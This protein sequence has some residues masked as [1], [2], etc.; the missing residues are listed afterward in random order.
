[1]KIESVR[2][3][4]F[5]GFKDDTITFD[6]YTCFVGANGAGKSTVLA[7]LNVFF[8]QYRDSKTDLSRLSV[9]DFHHKN[10]NDPIRITVTFADLSQQAKEDLAGYERHGKLIV[11]SIAHYDPQ[12]QR[13]EVKQYGS[14][15][16][17]ADFAAYHEA[18]KAGASAKDLQAI[19]EGLQKKHP[20]LKVAKTKAAMVDAMRDYE[21]ENSQSCV[22]LQSEDQFYGATKGVNRLA[23]HMQWI[24][25]P[26]SKDIADEGDEKKNSALGLLLAR[27]IR[28]KVS[29]SE[30]IAEIKS[31]IGGSYQSML[32][33]EQGVLDELSLSI[34]LKLKSWA[35]P[36]ATA[37]ILWKQDPEKS[38]KVEEPWAYIR[39]GERGFEGELAR[40]G[41]GMQR[42]CML[43]LLQEIATSE[44]GGSS[45]P[46][47]I[48]AIEEPE[49]YQHPPQ[50][51]YLA[52]V[53]HSLSGNG[54]QIVTCSH[55][56]LFV[57]G[58]SFE[59]VRV[60]RERGSPIESYVCHVKYADIAERLKDCGEKLYKEEG[61]QAKLYS[62]LNPSINEMFFCKS[63]VLVESMEDVAYLSTTLALEGK[64]E[65]F[66]RC[67]CHIVP[68]GRKSDLLRPA[69]I[70]TL[71]GIPVYVVFDADTYEA[72]PQKQAMHKKDNKSL[73]LA[74]QAATESE[75][76]KAD[77]WRDNATIWSTE[78]GAVAKEEVGASWSEYF[79]V[80]C[81]HYGDPGGLQK[82]PLAIS[83]TLEAAWKAG[84]K[85][86]S[87]V[88]LAE[89][90][91]AL[92]GKSH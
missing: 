10:V 1:M 40:F 25:V 90:V 38:V 68:V 91:L 74:L 77:I 70:A 23:P 83:K 66:R 31:A 43:T 26:A 5:R 65:E 6:N 2:I 61:I 21:A 85:S 78:I 82:N 35:H 56:P 7:A 16:G 18:D 29:F 19:F 63:L 53:L 9:D 32:D 89:N 59:A 84:A 73:L 64:M 4:N 49:L 30:R 39:V 11:S 20:K 15:L 72:N 67:G 42:S 76:P 51:K 92:A 86:K 24:F 88:R 12:T 69:V 37:K 58:D 3:E 8:R 45:V 22:P 55:S 87:L 80:A 33:S 34:E 60:V 27:T 46:T 28:A 47:L 17:I 79:Q 62:T 52:D 44:K 71:L 13:A 57:P 50:A 41:H 81:A 14:R 36:N 48:M 75:W 54:A